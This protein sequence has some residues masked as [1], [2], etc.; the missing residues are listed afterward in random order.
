MGSSA[1]S[2]SVFS[3]GGTAQLRAWRGHTPQ[4]RPARKGQWRTGSLSG[5]RRVHG[6]CRP[7]P[8]SAWSASPG[9]AGT[10]RNCDS[11][12]A[13]HAKQPPSR[14]PV[15]G[16]PHG[17]QRPE[18]R[19]HHLG[20]WLAL[21]PAVRQGARLPLTAVDRYRVAHPTLAVNPKIAMYLQ[22]RQE[23]YTRSCMY[24]GPAVVSPA[25]RRP[26]RDGVPG[27]TRCQLPFPA[28]REMSKRLDRLGRRGSC[29][30]VGRLGLLQRLDVPD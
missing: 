8:A 17:S 23:E 27:L 5:L 3:E 11:S 30:D 6:V 2:L 20:H 4:Q 26:S 19:L 28:R 25:R 15:M 14:G 12:R 10:R 24:G 7:A 13:R 29:R 22:P 18:R 21:A 9:P 16:Y 1:Y